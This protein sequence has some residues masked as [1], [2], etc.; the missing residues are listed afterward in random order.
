MLRLIALLLA[1]LSA[2]LAA[3]LAAEP[4]RLFHPSPAFNQAGPALARG[5]VVWLHGSYDVDQFPTSPPAQ[6]WLGRMAALG[7]DIWRFDR[8]PGQDKLDQGE[9]DL[10]HGLRMLRHDGYRRI[11]V[12]G[13]SRGAFIGL[14]ALAHPEL[15][16]AVAAISPAAHGTNPARRPAAIDAFAKLLA[17]VP[18]EQRHPARF[19]FVTLR[20]DPLEP[21]AEQRIALVRKAAART[22]L[23]L[24]LIDRPTDP[25][26]HMGGY[27]PAFDARFGA[28]LT[29]F[30]D[31]K[32]GHCKGG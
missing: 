31:G 3:P 9:A 24:L 27:D 26:G 28:C 8:V 22:G 25:V 18:H 32:D 14:A 23:K 2:P 1:L 7:Y 19:A 15:A 21:G 29:A 16:D 12:A 6:P 4:A 13:H 30:L 5:V 11:V 17:A 10:L 20:D